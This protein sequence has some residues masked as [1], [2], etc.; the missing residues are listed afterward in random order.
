MLTHT[1]VKVHECDICRKKF[2]VKSSLVTHFRIHL[3]EKPYGCSE[4]G[5]WYTEASNRNRHIQSY[6]KNLSKEQQSKLKC[7]NQKTIVYDYLKRISEYNSKD[8]YL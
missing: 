2:S 7:K 3:G 1:K 6:H 4:C 5:K 8:T